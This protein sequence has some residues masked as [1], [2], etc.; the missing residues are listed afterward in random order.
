MTTGDQRGALKWKPRL[1]H[2]M[3]RVKDLDRSLHFYT[4]LLGMH[5][6]RRTDYPEGKFTNTFIA[7][8]PEDAF[9]ADRAHPQLGQ[10]R[11]YA[12]R[13]MD[14]GTSPSTSRTST[15]LCDHSARAGVKIVRAGRADEARYR[16]RAF[17]EDPDGYRVEIAQPY[18]G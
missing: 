10:E 18:R 13:A 4:Q 14:T 2:L 1:S 3:L 8:G 5:V 6:L 12:T 7:Y 15:G 9:P 11:P 17:V 16:A